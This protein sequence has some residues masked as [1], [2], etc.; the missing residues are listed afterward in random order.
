MQ[1]AGTAHIILSKR[2]QR[3]AEIGPGTKKA[4]PTG[5]NWPQE[6]SPAALQQLISIKLNQARSCTE[7]RLSNVRI[8]SHPPH[9]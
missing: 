1:F 9:I 5:V 3:G 8:N 4:G 2:P 7:T 6:T